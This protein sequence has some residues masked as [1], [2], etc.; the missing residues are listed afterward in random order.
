M[1][2]GYVLKKKIKIIKIY[3]NQVEKNGKRVTFMIHNFLSNPQQST[4]MNFTDQLQQMIKLFKIF[5]FQQFLH[6]VFH[7]R[8][9]L[10][11]Q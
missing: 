11:E 9:K 1:T 4:Y 6:L 8:N 3:E 7:T 5:R 10:Q 2:Y